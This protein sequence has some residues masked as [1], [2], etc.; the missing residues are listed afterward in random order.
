MQDYTL[1]R[2]NKINIRNIVSNL[3]HFEWENN[4][5]ILLKEKLL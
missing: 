4:Y 2:N 3:K 5:N 1:V